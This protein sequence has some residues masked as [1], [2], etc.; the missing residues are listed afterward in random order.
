MLKNPLKSLNLLTNHRKSYIKIH[1]NL[2]LF[3]HI[4]MIAPDKKRPHPRIGE[5]LLD[6]GLIT[7]EQLVRALDRQVQSGDRLG[8][9][10]EGLG[11]L[12]SDTLLSVLGRQ[13]DSPFV[14]LYEVKVSPAIL[15]LLPFEQVK[16]FKAIPFSKSIDALSVAMVDPGD[17]VAVRNIEAVVGSSVKPHVVPCYQMDRAIDAFE[18]EGYGRITFEGEKLK[19]EKV[20]TE[21]KVPDIIAML[22][23]LGDFR[24]TELHLAAGASPG[25]KINNELKR[26]SMP[27]I[28]PAQM[29]DFVSE[30]L[31]KNQF[32][33]F[34]SRNELDTVITLSD[35]GRFRINVFRQR[36][37]ISL[38]ARLMYESI[39]SISDLHLPELVHDFALKQKGLFLITGPAGHDKPSTIAA[40]IDLINSNRSCN[41][42]TLEDPV[43][44]LH[45]HK[46]SNVN[47]RD[48]GI[49]T[50]SFASGL[51]HVLRQ[52][53][54]VIVIS[55]LRDLES[56]SAALHAAESGHLVIA[57]I[58]SLNTVTALEKILNI[59]PDIR[60][61][62]IKMQLAD[63][64]LLLISQKLVPHA[65]GEGNIR[66]YEVLMN[67]SRVANIVREGQ[68]SNI[69][70]MMQVVSEDMSSLDQ[71]LAG[72]CLE[73]KISFNDGLHS[74]DNAAYY[75]EIIRRGKI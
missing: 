25:M 64:L 62:Q 69:R 42:V 53:Q 63:T 20:V 24:A 72:L 57:A 54:D 7:Q 12:D 28:S 15:E 33:E 9:V 1:I 38:S 8:S 59:F 74:S 67:S 58:H 56:I 10:L 61:P 39:P 36:N 40:I 30:V 27:R 11:Y 68:V 6:Y 13:Y 73:G 44:Y 35:T 17:A 46:K 43:R 22:K 2:F 34:E 23:L 21:K 41:I 31:T 60:R 4:P 66:A 52:G 47:Q 5:I 37:S 3:F 45:T 14:N 26:L 71:S 55:D 75:Q 18:T 19:V 32:D 16:S 49:D 48:I 29:K 70:Q 51:K 50:D 65:E